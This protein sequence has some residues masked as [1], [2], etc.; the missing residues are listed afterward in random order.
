MGGRTQ[1]NKRSTQ[2]RPGRADLLQSV[3]LLAGVE[4]LGVLYTAPP[5][6]KLRKSPKLIRALRLL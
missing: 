4:F 2:A 3:D 6:Y 1:V 5:L